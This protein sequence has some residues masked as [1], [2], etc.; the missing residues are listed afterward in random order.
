MLITFGNQR[1]KQTGPCSSPGWDHPILGKGRGSNPFA[2][3]T[4]ISL[5]GVDHLAR[6]QSTAKGLLP[7]PSPKIV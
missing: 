3:E 1:V 4:R 2:I 7:L 6:E 5:S